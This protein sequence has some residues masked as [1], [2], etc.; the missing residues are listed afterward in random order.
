VLLPASNAERL[1]AQ[2]PLTLVPVH[3]VREALGL[4]GKKTS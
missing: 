3:H 2:F 4:V 1:S